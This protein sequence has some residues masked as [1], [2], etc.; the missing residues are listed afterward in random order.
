MITI[1]KIAELAG[2]SPSTVSN[3]LN[4]RGHKMSPA[5]LDKVK[6]ILDETNYVSNMGGRLLGNYGSKIIGVIMTYTRMRRISLK[7][8]SSVPRGNRMRL[9]ANIICTCS[10]RNNRI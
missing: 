5:T 2:V 4:G 6:K 3:V 1:K 7:V 9:P 10:Q 8:F